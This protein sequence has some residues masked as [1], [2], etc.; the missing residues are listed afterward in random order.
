MIEVALK[1]DLCFKQIDP[2]NGLK[3]S[4]NLFKWLKNRDH[5]S[6]AWLIRVYRE[7]C[8]TLWIGHIDTDLSFFSGTR[9]MSVLCEGGRAGSYA[10]GGE[11]PGRLS[12]VTDF[13]ERYMQDGRCAIDTDH[14]MSFVG[15]ISRWLTDGDIRTCCWC[16]KVSQ[17]L[18]KYTMTTECTKWVTNF[19]EKANHVTTKTSA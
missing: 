10:I 1:N 12:E 16:G 4:P 7:K 9:L 18:I 13:W 17:K 2:K 19:P 14:I 3:Y 11:L 5:K 15:D 8:G 6:R